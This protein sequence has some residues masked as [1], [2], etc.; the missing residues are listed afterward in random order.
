MSTAFYSDFRS[1]ELIT[2]PLFI[3]ASSCP[4]GLT[5][6]TYSLHRNPSAHTF[7]M[8]AFSLCPAPF[9]P[10]KRDKTPPPFA[11]LYYETRLPCSIHSV[12][13]SFSTSSSP[14]VEAIRIVIRDHTYSTIWVV[15]GGSIRCRQ[16]YPFHSPVDS[17]HVLSPF[18]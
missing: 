1:A 10:A 18:L 13:S 9:F 2:L 11:S 12:S 7:P 15:P 5:S 16:S 6:R 3:I 4:S 8:A 14:L 17:D